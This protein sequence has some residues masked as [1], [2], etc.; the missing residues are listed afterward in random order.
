MRTVGSMIV[1]F[2]SA[3][4]GESVSAGTTVGTCDCLSWLVGGWDPSRGIEW[5]QDPGY[6]TWSKFTS[7]GTT[8]EQPVY[9]GYWSLP[10]SPCPTLWTDG[11]L[12]GLAAAPQDIPWNV[13][14]LEAL[15][16]LG[17]VPCDCIAL[18]GILSCRSPSRLV[19]DCLTSRWLWL[20]PICA[21]VDLWIQ[22]PIYSAGKSTYMLGTIPCLGLLAARGA[23]RFLQ[24]AGLRALLVASLLCSTVSANVTFFV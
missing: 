14:W 2:R 20:S 19:R 17:L 11:F 3:V 8:L 1:A 21:I 6:R 18:G 12:S 10:D 7:F 13:L 22:P 15:A 4:E 23:K 9:A 24:N 5:W 16:W